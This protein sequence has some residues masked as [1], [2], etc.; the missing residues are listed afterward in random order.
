MSEIDTESLVSAYIELR[1]RRDLLLREYEDKDRELKADMMQLEAA[2]LTVCNTVNA[3]SIKTTHG[4]VMRRLVEKFSCS[5]WD[6]FYRFVRDH[7][8]VNLVEKRIHQGNLRQFLSENEG[9]GLPP[10]VNVMR[11]YGVTVRKSTT[12]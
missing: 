8:A 10:G 3:D 11:E 6:N 1:N 5:D 7:N 9:E 12:K 4:T 2:L